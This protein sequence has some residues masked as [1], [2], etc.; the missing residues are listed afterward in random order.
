MWS[1]LLP[2]QYL[3]ALCKNDVIGLCRL[4]FHERA[5]ILNVSAENATT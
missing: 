1:G 4:F 5:L 2:S 3:G